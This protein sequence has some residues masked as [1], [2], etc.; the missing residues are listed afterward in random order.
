VAFTLR[1]PAPTKRVAERRAAQQTPLPG[2]SEPDDKPVPG[3]EGDE[4]LRQRVL[5]RCL[6][7]LAVAGPLRARDLAQR[8][9]SLDGRIDRHLVNSVLH[10]EGAD[11]VRR[12]QAT[13][14]YR[15]KGR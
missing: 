9:A 5:Q 2:L 12:D 11:R 6:E 1:T 4:G 15:L 13:G 14:L 10:N 8:L 7:T 3:K